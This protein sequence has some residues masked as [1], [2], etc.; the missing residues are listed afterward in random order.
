M[1][2]P[3]FSW[4]KPPK[5]KKG[6]VIRT[7]PIFPAVFPAVKNHA[8]QRGSVRTICPRKWPNRT[9]KGGAW[10]ILLPVPTHTPPG[11][12]CVSYSLTKSN[13]DYGS[14]TP[15]DRQKAVFILCKQRSLFLK[16][17]SSVRFTRLSIWQFQAEFRRYAPV[18]SG[19]AEIHNIPIGMI[20]SPLFCLLAD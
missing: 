9:A 11:Q 19:R 15:P 3:K 1:S 17:T 4:R 12:A 5:P 8:I 16:A 14:Y 6:A 20:M 13:A 18:R 2:I 10:A 7:R